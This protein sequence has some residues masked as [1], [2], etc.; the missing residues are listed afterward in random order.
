M[1]KNDGLVFS[2]CHGNTDLHGIIFFLQ[3]ITTD[4][5][6]KHRCIGMAHELTFCDFCVSV[7]KIFWV[8]RKITFRRSSASC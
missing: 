8:I 6:D 3:K 4:K 1:E 2:V 7:A 5:Q